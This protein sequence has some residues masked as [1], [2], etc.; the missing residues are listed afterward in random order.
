MYFDLHTSHG[1]K[2]FCNSSTQKFHEHKIKVT[3]RYSVVNVVIFHSSIILMD[4][5]NFFKR[6]FQ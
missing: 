2:K 6:I 1:V 5:F 4:Y 3:N